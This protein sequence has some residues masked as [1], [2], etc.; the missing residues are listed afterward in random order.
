MVQLRLTFVGDV[1]A[2][3]GA[4][5]GRVLGLDEPVAF[6]ALEGRVHLADVERPDLAGPGL[7]LLP[8]LEAVL[9]PFAEQRQQGVPDAHDFTGPEILFSNILSILPN[10]RGL[11]RGS[12]RL[13]VP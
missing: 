5:V 1:E 6:E 7:E 3:L 12:T 8:Q 13:L 4:L 2:L 10:R 11:A 9:G